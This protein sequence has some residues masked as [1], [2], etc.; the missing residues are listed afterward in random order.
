MDIING[1]YLP[2]RFF[3]GSQIFGQKIR[4][5]KILVENLRGLKSISKF[6]QFFSSKFPFSWKIE[7]QTFESLVYCSKPPAP[8]SLTAQQ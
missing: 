6:V 4:D 2:G 8:T 3:K 5:L 1:E 7:V